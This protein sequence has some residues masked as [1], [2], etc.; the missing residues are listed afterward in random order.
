METITSIEVELVEN[1]MRDFLGECSDIDKAVEQYRAEY[2]RRLIEAY[3]GAT[4]SVTLG[5]GRAGMNTL[6]RIND[7]P[8]D[9]MPGYEDEIAYIEDI[10]G[11]MV[12]DWDWLTVA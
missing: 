5:N 4:V 2:E 7:D 6:Y 1:D 9:L 3:P 11:G 8:A 12:E 10:A